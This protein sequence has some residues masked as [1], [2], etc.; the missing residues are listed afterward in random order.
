MQDARLETEKNKL[1][2]GAV[3]KAM[4]YLPQRSQRVY[5]KTA[6]II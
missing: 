1:K 6:K 2:I 5:A 4:I 3:E